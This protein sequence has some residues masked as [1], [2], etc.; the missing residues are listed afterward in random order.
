MPTPRGWPVG[1]VD[2]IPDGRLWQ[3]ARA[4]ER[5]DRP[6]IRGR[7]DSARR[8]HHVRS[9]YRTYAGSCPLAHESVRTDRVF[10]I[11]AGI[12]AWKRLPDRS[13]V[14]PAAPTLGKGG[15]GLSLARTIFVAYSLW[16]LT[17]FEK[18]NLMSTLRVP[19]LLLALLA[20]V[21]ASAAENHGP[22][23]RVYTIAQSYPYPPWDVGPLDGVS[24]EVMSAICQANAP[25]QCKFTPV[26]SE[27]CFDTDAGGNA[28][29]GPGLA[30]GRFDGCLTWFRTEAREQLG[31]EFGHGFSKGA[32]PQLIASN[33]NTVF[34]S[35]Q[36]TGSLGGAEVAFFA[37]FF[38]DQTCLAT[39]YSDFDAFVSPSDNASREALV[40]DLLNGVIDLI[41]WDNISTVPAG[42]HPVGEPISTCGPD[43]QGLAVYPH[44]T[45]RK[46]RSDELRRDY[47]C[48]L[49]LI[50]L[51]GK[52]E[53]ICSTSQHPGGDP[54]CIL[55]GPPPT[56]Q[57]L[58]D[59]PVAQ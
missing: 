1:P 41:F 30:S 50:R 17:E 6:V 32:I 24:I 59:N 9:G 47:N 7:S 39:Q 34:D 36:A 52:L 26:R 37:G 43:S 53:A 14:I 42:T 4:R 56:V 49:A 51:S 58:E 3:V 22:E 29:V 35:L 21:A 5:L 2:R 15:R 48:G 19:F 10:G 54:E 31:A 25:M 38:S 45:S 40:S 12:R 23:T 33:D 46:A 13:L 44:S 28:V 57:C 27:E 20:A 11:R 16:S 18:E 55:G 8:Q